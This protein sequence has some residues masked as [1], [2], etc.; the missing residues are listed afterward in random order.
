MAARSV[1][2][3]LC[4]FKWQEGNDNICQHSGLVEFYR[5]NVSKDLTGI[6]G[7]AGESENCQRITVGMKWF[8]C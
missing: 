1:G 3:V 6:E 8:N 4:L 2:I 7:G 5:F